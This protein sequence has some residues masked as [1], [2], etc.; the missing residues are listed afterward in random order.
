MQKETRA[1]IRSR[2]RRAPGRTGPYRRTTGLVW[3]LP[4]LGAALAL[5]AVAATVHQQRIASRP[6]V[7]S[8]TPIPEDVARNLSAIPGATWDR[9]GA[10]KDAQLTLVGTPPAGKVTAAVLYVGAEYCPYCAALRWPVVA[11]LERFGTFTG[12]ALSASAADDIFPS[13]PTLTMLH[14]QYQSPY[15]T[16]QSVELQ[17]NTRDA[18]GQYP[19]LQRLTSSQTALFSHYDPSGNIPFLL[20]GSTYAITG[21]PFSPAVLQGMDWH[22]IAA[23]LP[24]GTAPAAQTIL[25]AANQISAALC[26]VNGGMPAAVCQSSGVR[27][28]AR[29]LPRAGK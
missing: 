7:V 10:G 24:L 9:A 22:A 16:V 5:V 20:I 1:T 19:T 3:L 23:G 25:A 27:D 11:A 18:S 8:Q 2:Q 15:V 6:A 12:L 13:T 26:A 17:G 14:A 28:A 4:A 21:A 29:L